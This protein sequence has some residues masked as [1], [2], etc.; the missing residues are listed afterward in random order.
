[1]VHKETIN[2]HLKAKYLAVRVRVRPGV[3]I[4]LIGR[5]RVRAGLGLMLGLRL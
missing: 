1:M 3:R 4:V 5:V 2:A